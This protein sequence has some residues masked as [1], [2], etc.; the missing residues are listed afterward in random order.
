MRCELRVVS[1]ELGDGSPD[2]MGRGV[3]SI[4]N[5]QL[6]IRKMRSTP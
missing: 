6:A 5:S 1:C 3:F 4:R 2:P